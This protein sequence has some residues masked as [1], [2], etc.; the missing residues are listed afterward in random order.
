MPTGIAC[1]SSQIYIDIML[2][3]VEQLLRL[4]VHRWYSDENAR[5]ALRR[6][7]FFYRAESIINR[8]VLRKKIS[9]K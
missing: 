9:F 8:I 3:A 6:N 4:A 7:F 5:K 1:D 2:I